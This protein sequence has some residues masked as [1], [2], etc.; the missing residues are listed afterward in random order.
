M[1][2]IR[3]ALSVFWKELQIFVRDRGMLAVLFLL[4]LLLGSLV[5]G[6]NLKI[7]QSEG[8]PE[9]LLDVHVINQDSGVFG[10]QLEAA[11]LD[12]DVLNVLSA[13]SPES[14]EDN[15]AKGDIMAAI[16]IPAGF[17]QDIESHIPT[18]IDV[19]V[20][21]AIPDSTSIVTGI[22]N[23]AADEIT[24][25]G[26]I[27]FGVRTILDE[28]GLLTEASQQV[29]QAVA[30]QTLGTIMT[31]L[32]E[33]RRD[34]A[35]VVASQDIEGVAIQ[36]GIEKYIAYVFA[37]FSVM[38]IFFI[39]GFASSSLLVEREDGTLPRILASP[40]SKGSVIGGKMLAYMLLACAQVALLF[41]VGAVFFEMPLGQDPIALILLTLAVAFVA[42]SMG[43]LVAALSKNS[44]QADNISMILAFVFAA[45]GGAIPLT[46]SPITRTEGF[47]GTVSLITPH[48][49]AVEGFYRLNAEA[50]GFG[51][52][53]IQIGVL[54]LMGV[55][56]MAIASRR[57]TFK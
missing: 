34:P 53:T 6:M 56:L 4:P 36:G 25:W 43:M 27:A 45:L 18:Q 10:D 26:E 24:I 55:V 37:A 14:A 5:G 23:Q 42:S 47:M 29:Q 54:L 15:V 20:D 11:L 30:A 19:F 28:S 22:I 44:R 51:D 33:M 32:N 16:I 46:G 49:Q 38:F 2:N 48:G 50:G 8:N 17:T 35:I 13:D 41:A 52:V 57:L 40:I 12:I 9:I 7:N 39:V 1:N 31:T 21:P 3:N